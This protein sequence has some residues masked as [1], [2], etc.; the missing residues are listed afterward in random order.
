MSEEPAPVDVAAAAVAG[1]A[2]AVAGDAASVHGSQVGSLVGSR[3]A[4]IAGDAAPVGEIGGGETGGPGSVAGESAH[5]R[6]THAPR[7]PVK[8]E[9]V[10]AKNR[11]WAEA[12]DKETKMIRLNTTFMVGNRNNLD[13]FPEKP[14]RLNLPVVNADVA[15]ESNELLDSVCSVK[16]AILLPAEKYELP[17]T[18]AQEVGFHYKPL[19]ER[20][21]MFQRGRAGCEITAYAENYVETT[22][23]G[24][25]AR[26]K[27]TQASRTSKGGKGKKK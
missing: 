15:R 21:P 11:R 13:I 20:N 27:V 25:Y 26:K 4:S 7:V 2:P 17:Q 16:D 12:C 23:V 9:D 1:D 24:P 22:G 8:L 6:G 18:M 10:V 5:G 19:V 14:N 3:A